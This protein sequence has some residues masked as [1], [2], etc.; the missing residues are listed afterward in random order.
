MK[1]NKNHEGSELKWGLTLMS[2]CKKRQKT[3]LDLCCLHLDTEKAAH[4]L[5]I[6]TNDRLDWKRNNL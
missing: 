1:E 5:E 6:F 4:C 2:P 3:A